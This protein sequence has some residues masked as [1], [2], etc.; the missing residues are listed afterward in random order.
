MLPLLERSTAAKALVAAINARV[1]DS[2]AVVCL[3][4]Q[5]LHYIVRDRDNATCLVQAVDARAIQAFIRALKTQPT[6]QHIIDAVCAPLGLLGTL[7]SYAATAL[8]SGAA[9]CL[10]K[11]LAANQQEE[12]AG[13]A[14]NALMTLNFICE[15]GKD[16]MKS[17][18]SDGCRLLVRTAVSEYRR[19]PARSAGEETSPLAASELHQPLLACWLLRDVAAGSDAGAAAALDEADGAA[20]MLVDALSTHL[21]KLKTV[22]MALEALRS[23]AKHTPAWWKCPNP[24]CGRNVWPVNGRALVLC[25]DCGTANAHADNADVAAA[26]VSEYQYYVI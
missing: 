26:R 4:S 2:S 13:L 6:N 11:V 10:C 20:A 17:L 9:P 24:T 21:Q 23:L 19:E 14:Q 3:A 16:A 22:K 15:N 12:H 8:R 25:C 18:T 1:G 7:P 5:L